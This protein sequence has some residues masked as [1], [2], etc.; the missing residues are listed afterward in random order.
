[1]AIGVQVSQLLVL[2]VALIHRTC[3]LNPLYYCA[4]HVVTCVLF[5]C[6]VLL[7]LVLL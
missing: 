5:L 7:S 6:H 1:M 2:G 3:N 4:S